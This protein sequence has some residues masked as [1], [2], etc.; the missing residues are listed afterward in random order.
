MVGPDV[1]LQLRV[2]YLILHDTEPQARLK[3]NEKSTVDRLK[4]YRYFF[5]RLSHS[6]FCGFVDLDKYHANFGAFLQIPNIG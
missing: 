1:E 4:F 2:K 6:G 3:A 5:C